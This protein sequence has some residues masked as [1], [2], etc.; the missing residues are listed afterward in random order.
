[1]HLITEV[2]TIRTQLTAL[3]IRL[4]RRL[5]LPLA[6]AEQA[7]VLVQAQ[8]AAVADGVEAPRHQFPLCQNS[9]RLQQLEF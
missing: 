2:Q 4:E 5:H 8:L 3:Q 1:M 9:C 7:L 6:P